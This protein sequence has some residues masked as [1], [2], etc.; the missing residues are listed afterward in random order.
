MHSVKARGAG[1]GAGG[2]GGISGECAAKLHDA[3][4]VG[5]QK[6]QQLA[7]L[8]VN[9]DKSVISFS[10]ER[11]QTLRQLLG[12]WRQKHSMPKPLLRTCASEIDNGP[13][14]L[15]LSGASAMTVMRLRSTVTSHWSEGS[16]AAADGLIGGGE[17]RAARLQRRRMAVARGRGGME[18][19][20]VGMA[21]RWGSPTA[22]K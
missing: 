2:E 8:V 13:M 20:A 15:R 11:G 10:V 3:A 7:A 12:S 9:R 21:R 14:K 17:Q 5:E 6:R 1:K 4:E 16:A 18:A 22:M 19:A